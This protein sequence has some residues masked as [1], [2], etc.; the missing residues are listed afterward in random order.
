MLHKG[1]NQMFM[2]GTSRIIELQNGYRNVSDS[3]KAKS[4]NS[5]FWVIHIKL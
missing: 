4:P 2:A 1:L 3:I 5:Y